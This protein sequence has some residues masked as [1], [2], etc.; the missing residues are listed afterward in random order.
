MKAFVA[1]MLM[2]S[3]SVS[4]YGMTQEGPGGP[5]RRKPTPRPSPDADCA[6]LLPGCCTYDPSCDDVVST[7]LLAPI[8][9]KAQSAAGSV[10]SPSVRSRGEHSP[11]S[12]ETCRTP[13]SAGTD[14][15]ASSGELSLGARAVSP[16]HE[17]RRGE[18]LLEG[19]HAAGGARALA[20]SMVSSYAAAGAGGAELVCGGCVISQSG[21]EMMRISPDDVLPLDLDYDGNDYYDVVITIEGHWYKARPVRMGT[22]RTICSIHE[23]MKRMLAAQDRFKVLDHTALVYMLY[24]HG[25]TLSSSMSKAIVCDRPFDDIIVC[26]PGDV[27]YFK[28]T[29]FKGTCADFLAAQ[30]MGAGKTAGGERG[31]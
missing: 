3:L 5:V 28:P 29:G 13:R 9:C 22:L 14:A 6:L 27:F 1:L 10:C 18:S 31:W 25:E 15:T 2:I 30:G 12:T 7:P 8:A 11:D 4:V 16:G 23:G 19:L 17:G 21:L 20:S 26:V 24:R